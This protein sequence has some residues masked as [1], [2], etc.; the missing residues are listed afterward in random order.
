MHWR[1]GPPA[2][3]KALARPQ[4]PEETPL[5]TPFH[6]SEEVGVPLE[7]E[8]EAPGSGSSLAVFTGLRLLVTRS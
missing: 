1:G 8:I 4:Q 6:V 2:H 3:H 5:P 7:R